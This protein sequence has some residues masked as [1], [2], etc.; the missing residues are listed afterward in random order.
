M[1]GDSVEIKRKQVYINGN[2]VAEKFK[3]HNDEQVYFQEDLYGNDDYIRDN[4]GPVVVPPGHCFVMGDN[5]DNSMDS[6]YWGFLP[7]SHIKGRPWVIYFSYQ[8]ERDAY[9]KTSIRDR[10]EKLVRFIPEAR[11]GRMFQV[12]H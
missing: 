5:R 6:R 8:A 11:W 1:E 7:L 3:V 10:L 9:L 2:P 4:F 12:I